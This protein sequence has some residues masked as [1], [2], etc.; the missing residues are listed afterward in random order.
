MGFDCLGKR[1][2]ELGCTYNNQR[3]KNDTLAVRLET[4]LTTKK[5]IAFKSIYEESFDKNFAIFERTKSE[6]AGNG[7]ILRTKANAQE[8]ENFGVELYEKK[9]KV[10]T[11]MNYLGKQVFL[12][13]LNAWHKLNNN[14]KIWA[15]LRVNVEKVSKS[16]CKE[17][18]RIALGRLMVHKNFR[19]YQ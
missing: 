9:F 19:G 11:L 5:L 13:K 1:G 10:S 12:K 8:N 4:I 6:L 14:G 16:Y 7:E 3:V 18:L 17:N 2:L 15:L